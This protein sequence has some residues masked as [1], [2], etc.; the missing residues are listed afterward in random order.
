MFATLF[1]LIIPHATL[2][3]VAGY[4]A[5][6]IA[7]VL[8]MIGNLLGVLFVKV[9]HLL[10]MDIAPYSNFIGAL[11]GVNNTTH[12]VTVGWT[13]VR[14][15]SNMFF[16]VILLV[17]AFGT[18]LGFKDYDYKTLLPRLLVMAVFIN[19]SRTITG[20]IIDGAQV[21]M[22]TFVNA[23]Q[24]AAGGNVI[25]GLGIDAL[26]QLSSTNVPDGELLNY[27]ASY[28]LAD[29]FL[30]IALMVMLILVLTL[31]ARIVMLWTITIMSP[32]AFF[33]STFP[34]GKEY[35]AQWWKQLICW[36]GSGPVLAFFLWLAL[37]TIATTG[38]SLSNT[39][40][41][42]ASRPLE[43]AQGVGLVSEAAQEPNIIKFIVGIMML[44]LGVQVSQQFCA[45]GTGIVSAAGNFLKSKAKQGAVMAVSYAAR[46]PVKTATAVGAIAT[47]GL[48]PGI[49]VAG[50]YVGGRLGLHYANR[51][52]R[53][54]KQAVLGVTA[55]VA[56]QF[57]AKRLAAMQEKPAASYKESADAATKIASTT[58]EALLA[59]AE[60]KR[61]GPHTAASAAAAAGFQE[62]ALTTPDVRKNLEKERQKYHEKNG[63]P[64]EEAE[65]QAKLDATERMDSLYTE[66][67]NNV[68]LSGNADVLAGRKVVDK[69]N[70][71]RITAD[72]DGSKD[73]GKVAEYKNNLGQKTGLGEAI[74]L[75]ADAF[76]DINFVNGL[77]E[78]V[79][80]A[81]R[82]GEKGANAKQAAA[83]QKTENSREYAALPK[84][85]KTTGRTPGETGRTAH[86]MSPAQQASNITADTIKANK[87]DLAE[88]DP[89]V[90]DN[91][92]DGTPEGDA[93]DK[94]GVA[95]AGNLANSGNIEQIQDISENP[96]LSDALI[97]ALNKFT[98]KNER[99]H[100]TKAT[101]KLLGSDSQSMGSTFGNDRVGMER[102]QKA[103]AGS[104]AQM[105]AIVLKL[106]KTG[107][108]SRNPEV[109]ET[110]M[111]N[112]NMQVLQEMS[113]A[114]ATKGGNLASEIIAKMMDNGI[115][116]GG[117]MS[118]PALATIANRLRPPAT[119]PTGPTIITP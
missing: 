108:I 17:I 43:G 39:N 111:N 66:Y 2:A 102:L 37:S 35:Y 36:A 45:V 109:A 3:G 26:Y 79:K 116:V 4:A 33:L 20:I 47:G 16:I 12:P 75:D 21:L 72:L 83:L 85:G 74:K 69:A 105:K 107:D 11:P 19:F 61:I 92:S 50:A 97:N 34:K 52:L 23:F 106:G 90:F 99:E 71:H 87:I 88:A 68:K 44:L 18:M 28:L 78:S 56:P 6:A 101:T 118:N 48:L 31:I 76:S 112:I 103:M 104:S 51:P 27:V 115:N 65:A 98:P 114:G 77:S 59:M 63:M 64:P 117:I 70:P 67:A 86:E 9:T 80:T 57:A 93:K 95:N 49:G 60:K 73:P 84:S 81:I 40:I 10:I 29:I 14:D 55:A 94:Q 96:A 119:P 41:Q 15:F 53:K 5:D 1:T 100:V 46:N 89:K 24:A 42:Q 22:L 113:A 38:A 25:N 30:G 8:Q 7:W 58:P 13:I 32:L 54:A 62:K 110:V 82:N 91:P